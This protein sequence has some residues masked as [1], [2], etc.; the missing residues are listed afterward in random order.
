VKIRWKSEAFEELEGSALWYE[1]REVGL[2]N[3]FIDEAEKALGLTHLL[4]VL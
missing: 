3:E 1:E 4:L 2:G